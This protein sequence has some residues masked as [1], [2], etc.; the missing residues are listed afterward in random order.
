MDII[1]RTIQ[2]IVPMSN[3]SPFAKR[4]WSHDLTTENKKIKALRKLARRK[5]HIRDHSIHKEYR[6]AR[7]D[8]T[9]KVE[10]NKLDHWTEY[11][12]E[13]DAH[14]IWTTHKYL[15]DELSDHF[16]SWI[17]TLHRCYGRR[18]PHLTFPVSPN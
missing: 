7:N 8:F 15:T 13:T 5:H 10:K 11:L 2:D 9:E 12:E 17:P 4:W 18:G 16:I 1:T 3:P 14:S 6:A